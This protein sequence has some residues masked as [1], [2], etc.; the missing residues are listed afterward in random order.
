MRVAIPPALHNKQISKHRN[1]SSPLERTPPQGERSTSPINT[2][3]PAWLVSQ[4]ERDHTYLEDDG[5]VPALPRTLPMLQDSGSPSGNVEDEL[6][7][8]DETS[9]YRRHATSSSKRNC[10]CTQ[11]HTQSPKITI[12]DLDNRTSSSTTLPISRSASIS[13]NMYSDDTLLPAIET[14]R[15]ENDISPETTT[16][17]RLSNDTLN[18]DVKPRSGVLPDQACVTQERPTVQLAMGQPPI[19]YSA[20]RFGRALTREARPSTKSVDFRSLTLM[21]RTATMSLDRSASS[22]SRPNANNSLTAEEQQRNANR[23]KRLKKFKALKDGQKK[24][25]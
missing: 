11:S 7:I 2:R 25:R 5:H 19:V 18:I 23:L 22:R 4:I 6:T 13:S 1:N 20:Q 9:V 24:R 10:L 8:T 14:V 21:S 16:A 12:E 15:L 3:L 17:P